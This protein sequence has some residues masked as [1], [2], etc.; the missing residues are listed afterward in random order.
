MRPTAEIGRGG[1]GITTLPRRYERPLERSCP[2]LAELGR[3]VVPYSQ[4]ESMIARSGLTAGGRALLRGLLKVGT[5]RLFAGGGVGIEYGG[6]LKTAARPD[7][8]AALLLKKAKLGEGDPAAYP[9]GAFV[10]PS[11][12]GVGVACN[13]QLQSS[14]PVLVPPPGS[15]IVASQRGRSVP[16]LWT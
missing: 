13:P 7:Y 3:E 14:S 12:T 10:I 4:T 11:Y 2:D 5:T 15:R 9:T 8:L 16:A 6:L 1:E